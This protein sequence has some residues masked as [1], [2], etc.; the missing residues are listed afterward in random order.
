M[1]KKKREKL[2]A[3][4]KMNPKK[5]KYMKFHKEKSGVLD[6][7]FPDL[8]GDAKK[9]IRADEERVATTLRYAL[10]NARREEKMREDRKPH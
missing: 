4:K 2:K 10:A 6:I 1:S 8:D 7:S 3:Q 9:E 5:E